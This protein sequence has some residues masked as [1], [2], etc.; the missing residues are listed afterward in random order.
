MSAA[1]QSAVQQI[2][3]NAWNRVCGRGKS[4]GCETGRLA[5]Q[6]ARASPV[7]VAGAHFRFFFGVSRDLFFFLDR[8]SP[9]LNAHRGEEDE[10]DDDE[11]LPITYDRPWVQLCSDLTSVV[12]RVEFWK[13]GPR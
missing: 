3:S 1:L 5:S 11:Q 8:M 4:A 2:A 9:A 12:N 7:P 13:P 10:E 6:Q